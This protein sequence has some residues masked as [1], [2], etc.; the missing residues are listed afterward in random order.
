MNSLFPYAHIA[1][2]VLILIIGFCFHWLGQLISI[3]NWDLAVRFGL[4]E[5]KM[6]QEYKVYE[7]GIAVADV[8]VGW[9]YG[10]AA[11]GLFLNAE[12]GYKMA[13]IPGS[14]LFYHAVSAWAWEG[15]RRVAGNRLWSEAFRI[16]W[17]V[18]NATTGVLA[19]LVAWVGR[20]V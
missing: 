12:W 14:I 13:W 10:V 8:A 17:C 5:R 7:H 16:G 9:L 11:L 1:A 18:V 4:Q 6:P 19:L 20:T 3:L 15:N 2:G